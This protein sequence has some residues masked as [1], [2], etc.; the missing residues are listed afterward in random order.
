[1]QGL[2][3]EVLE[4]ADVF[5]KIPMHGFTES[6][7]ISV[8][9]ALC[10]NQLTHNLRHSEIKWQLPENEKQELKLRWGKS[11]IRNADIVEKEFLKSL[12]SSHD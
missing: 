10:L 4:K 5:V 9:A 11:C 3:D 8:A 6:F 2:S 1:M 7:N 12:N